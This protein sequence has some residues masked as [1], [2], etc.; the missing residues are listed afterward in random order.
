MSAIKVLKAKKV[1]TMDSGRPYGTAIAVRDG[2]VLSVGSLEFMQPWLSRYEH[3]IDDTLKDKVIL[4]G[5]IDPH[6]HF[7]V[8]SGFLAL[9]YVGPIE[10]PSPTGI[11]PGLP[12]MG[13]VMQKLRSVHESM[14]DLTQPLVAWGV[15]PA[16]QGGH[17]DREK[18]D[19]VAKDRPIFVITYAPHF[20]YTNSAALQ[21]IALPEDTSVHGVGRYPDGRLNGQFVEI[22]ATR[23]A[24]GG[25]RNA[26]LT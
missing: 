13:A 19:A 11:N 3:S 24:L 18:L 16:M 5:F 12:D 26:I 23:L 2:R 14:K 22:E 10:S 4:P 25:I 7:A 17:L 15:D 20:V 8:S 1:V 21:R 6:T 9:H